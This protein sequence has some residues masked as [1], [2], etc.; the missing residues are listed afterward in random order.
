MKTCIYVL[1]MFVLALGI[2]SGKTDSDRSS[3]IGES[4][5]RRTR[6]YDFFSPENFA[7][8][9]VQTEENADPDY[10]DDGS[11]A[12]TPPQADGQ[13]PDFNVYKGYDKPPSFGYYPFFQNYKDFPYYPKGRFGSLDDN[14]IAFSSEKQMMEMMTI[15]NKMNQLQANSKKD[16]QGFLAKLMTDPKTYMLAAII[17]L[18][19]MIASYVPFV[20]S[21]FMSVPSMPAVMTTIV[22]SKMARAVQDIDLAQKVLENL[23]EFGS[24]VLEDDDCI[25][26]AVCEIALLKGG[27][28]N[29]RY[30]AFVINR[31]SKDHWLKNW[32]VKELVSALEGSSCEN[33]CRSVG[34]KVSSKKH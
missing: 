33:V 13:Y 32:G 22:T 8:D 30:A 12:A 18:A 21:Y 7:N 24:K 17:P 25:Q 27:S 23:I 9:P 10:T 6:K 2:A 34:K 15:M 29:A 31:V 28:D 14:G 16:E 19:V 3:A 11:D 5:K 4:S 1:L 26:K 20:A